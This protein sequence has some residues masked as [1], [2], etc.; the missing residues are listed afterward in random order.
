MT[1]EKDTF[2]H[3]AD[4]DFA[5]L[6]HCRIKKSGTAIGKACRL[7]LYR[8]KTAGFFCFLPVHCPVSVQVKIRKRDEREQ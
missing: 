2:L 7:F 5:G 6:P 8:E 3:R 4:S 1:D